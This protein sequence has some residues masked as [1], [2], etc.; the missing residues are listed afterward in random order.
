MTDLDTQDHW[1]P[2]IVLRSLAFYVAAAVAAVPF[3]LLWPGILLSRETVYAVTDRYLRVQL[4]LLKVIC[5]IRY[6]VTG[7]A[8]LPAEPVLIAS[9]HE[10]TWETLFYQL[11]LGRP[12][13]YAKQPIFSYPIFGPLMRKLEHIPVSTSAS[14]DAMRDGFRAGAAAVKAGR[15]LLIFPSGT[16]RETQG[17]K[18]QSGVGVLYQLAGVPAVPVRVNSGACWPY[19]TFLKFPGTIRVEVGAPIPAGLDRRSFMTQLSDALSDDGVR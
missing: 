11:L 7:R 6:E 16:R 14:G 15:S 19:G 12:V 9:Q 5:G 4:W 13:M 18:M 17:Q 10:S 3:L 2:I 8:H 1:R